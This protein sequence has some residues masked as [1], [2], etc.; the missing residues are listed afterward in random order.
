LF[1]S[2]K[3]PAIDITIINADRT[4]GG[5]WSADLI[6]PSLVTNNL[7]ALFDY[8]DLPM[9]P[10]IRLKDWSDPSA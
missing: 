9:A 8:S 5:V 1:A 10:T 7:A 4:L 3:T 6:Y 2:K